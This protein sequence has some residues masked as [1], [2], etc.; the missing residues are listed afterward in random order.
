[1]AS[2]P[3]PGP[4]ASEVIPDRPASEAIPDA[5]PGPARASQAIPG[6]ATSPKPTLASPAPDMFEPLSPPEK[7]LGFANCSKLL[8]GEFIMC[9]M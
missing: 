5:I 6:P 3:I 2:E 9:A 4:M 1:M 8:R 7:A